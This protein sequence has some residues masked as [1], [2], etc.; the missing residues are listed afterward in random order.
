[1]AGLAGLAGLV[2]LAGWLGWLGWLSLAQWEAQMDAKNLFG[3]L[4]WD[5]FQI[6]KT[7]K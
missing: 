7:Q 1:M 2:G 5:N 6:E 4:R 3:V